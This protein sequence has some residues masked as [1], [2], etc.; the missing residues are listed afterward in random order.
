MS[1]IRTTYEKEP[2][3]PASDQHPDAVR[4][5]V[6]KRWV[7]A[8][9]GRPTQAE[10]DAVLDPPE[11]KLN[12]IR[13]QMAVADLKIIRALVEGDTVRIAA[14]VTAQAA[15]RAKLLL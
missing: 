1:T 3:F 12:V 8:I 14:H 9:G 13:A 10:V 4:Y 2:D 15:L 7:D 6:G 11:A 5:Q